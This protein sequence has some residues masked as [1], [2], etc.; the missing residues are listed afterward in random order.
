MM[1]VWWARPSTAD[2]GDDLALLS[3]AEQARRSALV[4][5]RDR[6]RFTTGWALARRTLSGLTG[7]APSAL[8][9]D[10]SCEHCGDP[11]HGRPRL[12]TDA[13]SFSL[14]HSGDRVLLAVCD[15]GRVG[16]DVEAAGRS[17]DA[18][19]RWVL[20]P[21]EPPIEGPEL[22]RGWVRKEAVAKASGYGL[23]LP[24]SGFTLTDPPFGAEVEDI[25]AG[26]GY[27]AAVAVIAPGQLTEP[28]LTHHLP[29]RRRPTRQGSPGPA[30]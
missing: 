3:S 22:L 18:L 20:H 23:T 11:G 1:S 6:D 19:A 13:L 2:R 10:R 17:T 5:P 30:E 15:T 25:P 8:V 28:G 24:M 7:T 9:F 16:A 21:E 27:T 26:P 12:A 14:S 4:S 29:A